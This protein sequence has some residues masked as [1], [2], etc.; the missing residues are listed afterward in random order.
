MVERKVAR[1]EWMVGLM[2]AKVVM[3]ADYLAALDSRKVDLKVP[4]KEL[5]LVEN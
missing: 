4:E 5:H 2:A 3:T 1:V